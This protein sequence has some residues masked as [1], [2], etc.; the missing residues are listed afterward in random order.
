LYGGI[1][2]STISESLQYIYGLHL[3]TLVKQGHGNQYDKY[4][5]SNV[6]KFSI[7]AMRALVTHQGLFKD[8][9]NQRP[10]A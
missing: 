3:L 1:A 2:N 4:C 7:P 6:Y 5:A 10:I 8:E 9:N